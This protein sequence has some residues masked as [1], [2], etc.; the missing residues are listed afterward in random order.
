MLKKSKF[1]EID[2]VDVSIPT[3]RLVEPSNAIR[4][5]AVVLSIMFIVAPI[6]LILVPWQQT[7]SGMGRVVAYAP[8]DRQQTIQAP[9]KGR[10]VRS[11]VFEGSRVKQ[12]EKIFEIQDNDPSLV[13]RLR[14]QRDAA[15]AK[16]DA[17]EEKAEAYAEQVKAFTEA[18][19]L[20]IEAAH[21][22]VSVAEQKVIAAQRSVDASE[23]AVSQS[24][25][26][27]ER[28][29]DLE[30]DG[31]ASR[32]ELEKAERS[33][34]EALA[35][36]EQEKAYLSAA[37]NEVAAK[38]ADLIRVGNE[39]GAKINSAQATQRAAKG[40]LATAKKELSD[41]DVKLSRQATQIVTAPRDGTILRL[42]ANT[43][44]EMLKEGDPLAILV[45]D[46]TERA[47][48]LWLKGNDVPLV[49]A[50]EEVRLQF[51]GWPAL[52]FMGWP[53]VAVGTFPGKISLVDSTDDGNGRFRVLVVPVEGDQWP[54][55]R[56]LRQGVRAKGWV[57][58]NQVPLGYELWRQLNGFPPVIAEGAPMKKVKRKK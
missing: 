51:E 18:R 47:V 6:A 50:G 22:H 42:M 55:D 30:R 25:L 48:E 4:K 19:Q 36:L 29:R 26:N 1:T 41:A 3:L 7:V 53:S 37:R 28:Q 23:A 46:T 40:D 16:V 45:P 17:Y 56:Y 54:A 21:N 35:K 9:I 58:L 8:L 24:E 44:A 31:L 33:Y 14:F 10:I 39:A 27:Y 20:A 34:K 49:E 43:G 2:E 5:L 13:E 52:Q 32:L 12:G 57:L 15:E 11:W 38:Q